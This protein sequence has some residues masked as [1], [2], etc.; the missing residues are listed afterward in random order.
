MVPTEHHNNVAMP[1]YF[2]IN[3]LLSITGDSVQFMRSIGRTVET[4]RISINRKKIRKQEQILD[5]NKSEML[6]HVTLIP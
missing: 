2:F 6:H 4:K 1:G 3:S 5:F